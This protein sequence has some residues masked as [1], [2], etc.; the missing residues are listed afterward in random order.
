M[1]HEFG[2]F[3]GKTPR[4]IEIENNISN[5]YFP[6]PRFDRDW[7]QWKMLER[8]YPI[9]TRLYE[10]NDFG[11]GLA[12]L[13]EL[14]ELGLPQLNLAT[15]GMYRW[16]FLPRGGTVQLTYM[17][18]T[19]MPQINNKSWVF[20]VS[21]GMCRARI[22]A[23]A[24][25]YTYLSPIPLELPDYAGNDQR[26]APWKVYSNDG[27][28]WAFI[29][30]DGKIIKAIGETRSGTGW[31]AYEDE[32]FRGLSLNAH[33]G[34]EIYPIMVRHKTSFVDKLFGASNTVC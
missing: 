30:N 34:F 21:K 29:D 15:P 17:G 28:L 26:P 31:E 9:G 27:L 33:D 25:A 32:R 23:E 3:V 1:K 24:V 16:A 10:T 4:L 20:S 22:P 8:D 18:L 19:K 5:G 11:D 2:I 14:K 12:E 13:N 6:D 7:E